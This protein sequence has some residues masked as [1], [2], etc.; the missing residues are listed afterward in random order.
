MPPYDHDEHVYQPSRSD[1]G[2]RTKEMGMRYYDNAHGRI[3]LPGL[4]VSEP[5][6]IGPGSMI[7]SHSQATEAWLRQVIGAITHMTSLYCLRS[8][9]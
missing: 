2:A 5:A 4:S 1:S 6:M 9:F 8:S 3:L 7:P